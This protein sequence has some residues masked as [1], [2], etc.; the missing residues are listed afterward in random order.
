MRHH[1]IKTGC[2]KIS[3]SVD[4]VE[5]LIFDSMSAHCD[6]ELKDRKPILLQDNLAQDV[7]SPYQIWLQKVQQLFCDLDLDD[8]KAI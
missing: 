2:K 3:K 7:A 4:V 8:N 1:P 6:P 5:T